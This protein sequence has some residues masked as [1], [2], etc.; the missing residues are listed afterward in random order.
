M[1]P[2]HDLVDLDNT[3]RRQIAVVVAVAVAVAVAAAAAVEIVVVVNA[4]LVAFFVAAV[5]TRML[6]DVC[7]L[8]AAVAI[9][10]VFVAFLTVAFAFLP[11]ASYASFLVAVVASLFAPPLLVLVVVAFAI[12]KH[13]HPMVV[14]KA[15]TMVMGC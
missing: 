8:L 13:V 15:V 2:E 5:D 4:L 12:P 3:N 1:V 7:D 10:V 14:T 9:V 11:L 6:V